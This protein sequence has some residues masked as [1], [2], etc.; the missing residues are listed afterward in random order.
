MKHNSTNNIGTPS[1]LFSTAGVT[2]VELLVVVLIG[3]LLAVGMAT[4]FSAALGLQQNFREESDVRT[5][6]AL[7]LAY[8][9]RYLSLANSIDTNNMATY[10]SEAGGVSFET[11]HWIRVT[12]GM[13]FVTNR[14]STIGGTV[15]TNDALVFRIFSGDD[16]KMP[17][18][19]REFSAFGLQ[20]GSRAHVTEAELEGVGAVRR[21]T[22]SA[23]FP[24]R[25]RG[26]IVTNRTISVSRPIRLWNAKKN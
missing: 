8:A 16:R 6:L 11:N 4:A 7:N 14:Q 21:L 18:E 19:D 15:S 5:R 17:G 9:E 25:E 13:F 10:P 26:V 1:R 12:S 24:V 22:L 23:E 20:R 3:T 2:V